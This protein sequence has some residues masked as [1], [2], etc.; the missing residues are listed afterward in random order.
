MYLRSSMEGHKWQ[1]VS[2]LIPRVSERDLTSSCSCLDEATYQLSLNNISP[3]IR[4]L[5][6]QCFA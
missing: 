2:C 4:D 6:S 5:F 3:S 1:A